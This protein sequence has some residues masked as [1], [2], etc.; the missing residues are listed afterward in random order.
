MYNIE[1]EKN[2]S[3]AI[4]QNLDGI[5]KIAKERI[6]QELIKILNLKSFLQINQSNYLKE[7]FLMIFPELLYLKR[8]ERL[9]KVYDY[10]EKNLDILLAVLVIDDKFFSE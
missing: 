1:V 10:S 6:L 7:I 8:L 3:D 2:T 4:K 9:K 5:R